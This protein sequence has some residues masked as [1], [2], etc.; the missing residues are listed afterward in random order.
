[1]SIGRYSDLILQKDF[2]AR[3]LP[4]VKS[5]TAQVEHLWDP[6]VFLLGSPIEEIFFL[7]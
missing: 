5:D 7:N 3:S 2:L 6:A 1:M 4:L